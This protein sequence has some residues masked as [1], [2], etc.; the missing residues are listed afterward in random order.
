MYLLPLSPKMAAFLP[1]EALSRSSIR[2][3]PHP[4]THINPVRM[5]VVVKPA[6]L[7]MAAPAAAVAAVPRPVAVSYTH[8]TLPTI[9]RV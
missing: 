7:A 2:R 5:K 6:R 3:I 1:F 9:L 8:L 4:S